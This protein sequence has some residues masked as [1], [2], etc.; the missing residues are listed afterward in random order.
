M[1]TLDGTDIRNF[2]AVA[3]RKGERIALEGVFSFPKRKGT[4][5]RNWL[6]QIEPFVDAEDLEF[7]GRAMTLSVW[8]RGDSWVQYNDR[9]TAFKNACIACRTL[10]TEYASFP[11]VLK[12]SVE[13]EEYIGHN[14]AFVSA[15]FWQE[16]VQFPALTAQSSGG[17]GYR[18]DGFN[19]LTDFGI[20]VYK[21][22]DNNDVGK[23]IET[24]T[25]EP[26]TLTQYRDKGTAT[27]KCYLRGES[28][29]DIYAKMTRFHALCASSGLR[30]L[31]L[32]DGAEL[33][34]YVKDGFTAKAEHRTKVSFDF[35]LRLI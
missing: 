35:K 4:T 28:F 16:T 31:H 21:R 3:A 33:S 15:T 17:D 11:V 27:F 9:L 20:R 23:R 8:L 6:T 29:A 18:I 1:Y 13:V 24:D 32:P 5:E 10:A 25:T 30:T 2:G 14:R 34:G 7:D 26:Y 19:L 22:Q 12:D